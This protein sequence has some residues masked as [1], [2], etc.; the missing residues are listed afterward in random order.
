MEETQKRSQI[1]LLGMQGCYSVV[2]ILINTFLIARIFVVTNYSIVSVG[3]FSLVHMTTL[4]IAFSIACMVAK[5]TKPIYMIRV[6]TVLVVLLLVMLL[7]FEYHLDVYFMLFGF[8]WGLIDGFYWGSKHYLDVKVLKKE[9][10]VKFVLT[11]NI[12]SI[13]IALIFP[14]TI[15][16]LIDEKTFLIAVAI[17]MVFGVL[18]VV[19]STLI[20]VPKEVNSNKK[21]RIRKY[22]QTMKENGKLKTTY[23]IL[24]LI[25]LMSFTHAAT[26]MLPVIIILA[27]GTNFSL[28][29][30]TT[31]FGVLAIV[32]IFVYKKIKF[33]RFWFFGIVLFISGVPLIF[34]IGVWTVAIFQASKSIVTGLVQ[35]ETG[36]VR[37]NNLKYTG[38]E[39]YLA[40]NQV[41]IDLAMYIAR[42]ICCGLIIL[43]GVLEVDLM[44]LAV[45]ICAGLVLY[46]IGTAMLYQWNQ[47]NIKP[48]IVE[49]E[50]S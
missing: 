39:E 13:F 43:V 50:N 33:Q 1:G 27:F 12:I 18:L 24:F 7:V 11:Q 23:L 5:R 36:I 15:G 44:W 20:Q 16:I 45:V 19:F 30:L 37:I 9:N 10:V 32:V 3:L 34:S 31:I 41:L 42:A 46:A 6:A 26:L 2:G 22:L 28:G 14:F 29:L 38:G 17:M 48:V 4:F 21:L 40:E 47:K 25:F 8:V 49:I 35:I